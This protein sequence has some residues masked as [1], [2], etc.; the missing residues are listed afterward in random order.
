VP[1]IAAFAAVGIDGGPVAGTT[2]FGA[3]GIAGGP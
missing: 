2:A 3:V 1:G